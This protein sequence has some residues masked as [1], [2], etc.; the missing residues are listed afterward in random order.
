RDVPTRVPGV[1][2]VKAITAGLAPPLAGQ[3]A[4]TF[5]IKTDGSVLA[6]GDNTHGLLGI[7]ATGGSRGPAP[8]PRLAGVTQIAASGTEALAIA[9][10]AGTVWAGG[11]NGA[12]AGVGTATPHYSPTPTG[13][14]GVRQVTTEYGFSAAVLSNGAVMTWGDG[15]EGELGNGT[16][17]QSPHL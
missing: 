9:G 1:S 5:A 11:D 3:T 2:G 8:G 15:S 17:D 7:G 4:A 6:W 10:A 16:Q 13:L 12:A 14:T